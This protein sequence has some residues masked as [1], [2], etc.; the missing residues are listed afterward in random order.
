MS[1]TTTFSKMAHNS[2]W[3]R[4]TIHLGAVNT[5][6]LGTACCNALLSAHGFARPVSLS[7][8][9][10]LVARGRTSLD[11]HVHSPANLDDAKNMNPHFGLRLRGGECTP[12][13]VAGMQARAG[14]GSEMAAG[15]NVPKMFAVEGLI[16]AGKSTLLARLRGEEVDACLC[17]C[18]YVFVCVCV[19]VFERDSVSV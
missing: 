4:R 5:L 8:A 14:G 2:S 16:G 13:P 18:I 12:L 9:P 3:R 11:R 10:C 6:L 7:S 1:V 19:C 17:K 15:G